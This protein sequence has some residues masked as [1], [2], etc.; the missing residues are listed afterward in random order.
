MHALTAERECVQFMKN[1]STKDPTFGGDKEKL[2]QDH[3]KRFFK[4]KVSYRP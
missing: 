2:V 1:H 4:G 3:A